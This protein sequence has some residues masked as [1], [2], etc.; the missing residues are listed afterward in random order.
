LD[1]IDLLIDHENVPFELAADEAR[2]D[3]ALSKR[4]RQWPP[5]LVASDEGDSH[6]VAQRVGQSG[7]RRDLQGGSTRP[8]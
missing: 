2:P 6:V 8:C 4:R 1:H 5:L 3:R 7:E